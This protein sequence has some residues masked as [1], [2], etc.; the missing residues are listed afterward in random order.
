MKIRDNCPSQ[1]VC[2]FFSIDN[3]FFNY[4]KYNNH[5]CILIVASLF[6]LQ[7]IMQV[8]PTGRMYLGTFEA[9]LDQIPPNARAPI[10][11]SVKNSFS[12]SDLLVVKHNNIRKANPNEIA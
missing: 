7:V 10:R 1:F 4:Y 6:Q 5:F 9:Y 11:E 12:R 3:N 2:L 8:S